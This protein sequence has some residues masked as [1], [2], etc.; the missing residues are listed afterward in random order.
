MKCSKSRCRNDTSNCL[1]LECKACST[2]SRSI[3]ILPSHSLLKE[4]MIAVKAFHIMF[5]VLH[6][7]SLCGVERWWVCHYHYFFSDFFSFFLFSLLFFDLH[8][9]SYLFRGKN[10]TRLTLG[11][12]ALFPSPYF[13]KHLW[14]L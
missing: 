11:Q 7:L 13:L 5:F 14:L 8:T 6:V 3:P 10:F 1:S 4:N 9:V 12:P 2:N